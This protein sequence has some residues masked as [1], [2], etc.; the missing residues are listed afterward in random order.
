[1][2]ELRVMT[3]RTHLHDERDAAGRTQELM[4]RA[5]VVAPELTKTTQPRIPLNIAIVIDRSGSM[6]GRK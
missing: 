2:P 5:T 1:M 6:A 4:V 3:N